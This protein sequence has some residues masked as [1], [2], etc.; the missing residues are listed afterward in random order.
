MIFPLKARYDQARHVLS[1]LLLP[2]GVE[3]PTTSLPDMEPA[4]ADCSADTPCPDVA[5]SPPL[6]SAELLIAAEDAQG[7]RPRFAI[8]PVE[9]SEIG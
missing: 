3:A 6:A 9:D 7:A 4:G 8:P 2:S 5:A 1:P